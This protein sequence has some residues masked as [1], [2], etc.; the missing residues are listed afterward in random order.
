[1]STQ[2]FLEYTISGVMEQLVARFVASVGDK[3]GIHGE[4][5]QDEKV[6]ATVRL[7]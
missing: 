7:L 2:E 1:M 3:D 6:S 5:T 4:T